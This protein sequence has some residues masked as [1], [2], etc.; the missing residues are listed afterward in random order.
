MEPMLRIIILLLANALMAVA[1]WRAGRA[2]GGS[3]WADVMLGAGV[4]FFA[5][6]VAITASLGFAGALDWRWLL[7]AAFAVCAASFV[8][9][10]PK[11]P[12]PPAPAIPWRLAPVGFFL[13]SR[14]SLSRAFSS[15]IS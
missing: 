4:S 14:C 7:A 1:A 5:G 15:G 10:R 8:V 11:A 12:A 13:S 2:L 9:F 3:R 6:V